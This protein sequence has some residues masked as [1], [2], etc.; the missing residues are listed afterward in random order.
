MKRNPKRRLFKAWEILGLVLLTCIA[1]A[2]LAA[3]AI[4]IDLGLA[5]RAFRQRVES[6]QRDLAHRFGSTEAVLTSLVGLHHASDDFRSYEFA[7]LSR[8]L[9]DAYPY[10]G[11]IAKIL[12]IP[13]Q[14]RTGF[15]QSMRDGGFPQFQVTER[16][17]DGALTRAGDRPVT[18][19]I[20]L[21]EPF[22]PEF[23]QL[24]GF[25]VSSHPSLT[26]AVETAVA[27]GSVV[28][29]DLLEIPNVGQGMFVFKAF[30]LGYSSP[31]SIDARKQHVSG[32]IAL[33]LEPD[34]LLM[35]S[36]EAYENFHFRLLAKSTTDDDVDTLIF[37]RAPPVGSGTFGVFDP[38]VY[39]VPI[40]Q[41]GKI[42][43]LE[44]TAHPA[45]EMIRIWLALLLFLLTAMACGLFCLAL[46]NHRI[47][48]AQARESERIL[49]QNEERF[50][51][52]AEVASDWF[53][54]TDQDLRFN[55]VS[56]RLVDATGIEPAA[57]LGKT[58]EQLSRF[59][60]QDEEA[61][62]HVEDLKARRPFKD[63]R[64]QFSDPERRSQW[65]SVSG[66]PVFDEDGKFIGYRGTG[67]N[68]TAETEAQ[69]AL[70]TSKEEAELA[71]RAKS[72]FL[73]NMSHE[74]R[75]PLN[76]I[77]GFSEIIS[78]QTF[79]PLGNDRYRDY[80]ADIHES[81]QHLLAL[82][83]NILDLS[84]VESGMDELYEEEI[85]VP[86]LV[87]LLMTLIKSHAEKA[88]VELALDLPDN[89]P[90][91]IADERKLKQILVNLLGNAIKFTDPGGRVRLSVCCS[92]GGGFEFRIADTG[93]GMAPEDILT[94][95]SKFRQ[96][97]SALNRKY[98][99]TGL[100]LPLT[101]ALT[102]LHG[103][104]LDIE[105]ALGVGTT[106]TVRLPA[107]RTVRAIEEAGPTEPGAQLVS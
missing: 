11:I 26:Q 104:S 16:G 92:D 7:A 99:G 93:I 68:I 103:G 32:L 64:Y 66:K 14:E 12:V 24:I 51:D 48:L 81:G 84:K 86:R 89:L 31:N 80:A 94:A 78:S 91:L 65:W 25:D 27:S 83:N 96:V 98:E 71:N 54:S 33:Y 8:E 15:E 88:E 46:K 69:Q 58:R 59:S 56:K 3:L 28:S 41:H 40:A 38:F 70:Q 61:A 10:I 67:T 19:P 77:I 30:Y 45:I 63:F 87:P 73:A 4:W 39:Q 107:A 55:Y 17:P 97:D 101:K 35:D 36:M 102:E 18:M 49:R 74:L 72:E 52:F 6:V 79:G 37:E 42:F 105:S 85:E 57:L 82:I 75:T 29:S 21:L 44:V 95:F 60:P 43:V 22:N 47:G 2:S 90:R 1:S 34:R 76:A 13:S 23:A 50:R 9:L 5:E 106:V 62:Q 100:G 53:W 20:Q